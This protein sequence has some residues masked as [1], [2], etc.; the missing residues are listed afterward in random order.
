MWAWGVNVLEFLPRFA[1]LAVV[2]CGLAFVPKVAARLLPPARALGDLVA[3]RPGLAA[4]GF[5]LA[6]AALV[7]AL[8]D[9]AHF[10]GDFLLRQGTVEI[11]L[12]PNL[13]FPQALPLDILLHYRIPL[14]LSE[15]HL[16]DAGMY[17]RLLGALEAFGLAGLAILLARTLKLE[18][19]AACAF[20]CAAT[21]TGGLGLMTGYSKAFSELALLTLA[22]AAFGTR[23]AR[24]G[25]GVLALAIAC[26]LGLALHR[27]ALALLPSA[28]LALGLAAR[29]ARAR[30]RLTK[31]TALLGYA[32]LVLVAILYL[33][34]IVRTATGFDMSQHFASEDVTK[35]GGLLAASFAPRRLLDLANLFVFLT[36]L[37]P[38]AVLLAP[39]V[40]EKPM[41]LLAALCAS[42]FA[43]ALVLFPAQGVFRDWDVF[44]PAGVA[45]AALAGGL[46][47][48]AMDRHRATWAGT[49][50][51]V[52][53]LLTTLGLLAAHD[54]ERSWTRV[55]AFVTGPP[56]RT[57]VERSKT[58]DFLGGS[59]HQAGRPADAARAFAHAAE[60]SR[61]Q[62]MYLQWAMAARDAGDLRQT[63]RVL[64][65]LV[66]FAPQTVL[67]WTE[68]GSASWQL[69]DYAEAARA[70]HEMMRLSPN[71]ADVRARGEYVERFYAAW[72]DSVEGRSPVGPHG[73]SRGAETR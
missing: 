56:E 10:V 15:A 9:R 45:L 67:A 28:L 72:R 34:A 36:P 1:W 55:E 51:L 50:S 69:G 21:F 14:V 37:A 40:R 22:V 6:A 58:W 64:Q 2:L 43:L 63:Q 24:E 65:E 29:D 48:R 70:A 33:P 12:R 20:V 49:L 13:L 5:G 17:G 35:A 39:G 54:R 53:V 32:V 18:G 57:P 26:A 30:P 7:F 47:A 19:A 62:R 41:F 68:L 71:D 61:S 44:V 31:P 27:S 52:C 73:T 42:W 60:T 8:P 59:W 46:A 38:L 66:A 3:R 16:L 25:R 4:C 23:V 11:S